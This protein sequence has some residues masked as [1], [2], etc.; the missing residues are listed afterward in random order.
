[1][2]ARQRRHLPHDGARGPA[3]TYCFEEQDSDSGGRALRVVR[4]D[5]CLLAQAR[6]CLLYTSDAADDM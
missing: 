3:V 4:R 1:M 5:S 2:P 6:A